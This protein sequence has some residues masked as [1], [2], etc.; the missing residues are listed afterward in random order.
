MPKVNIGDQGFIY[1]MPMTLVGADL[2]SGPNFMPIAW[3][4]R[5]QMS[6]PRLAAG[7]NKAHATNAGIREHGEFSVCLPSV[8]QVAVTD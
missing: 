3:I 2:A 8:D 5:V 6:P 4:N 1:P 7:M